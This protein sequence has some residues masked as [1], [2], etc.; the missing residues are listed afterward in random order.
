M[1]MASMSLLARAIVRPRRFEA[2]ISC[3]WEERRS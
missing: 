1:M 2:C 3:G